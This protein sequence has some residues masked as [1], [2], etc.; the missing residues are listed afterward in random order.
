MRGHPA[1]PDLG[2]PTENF[3]P[4]LGHPLPK[5]G[6]A[7]CPRI[8]WCVSADCGHMRTD[9]PLYMTSLS[10]NKNPQILSGH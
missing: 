9:F 8:S 6:Y 10:H 2:R 5:S 1:Y 3:T 4:S 7:G